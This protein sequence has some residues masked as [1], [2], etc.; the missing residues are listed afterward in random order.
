MVKGRLQNIVHTCVAP[1][2]GK[3]IRQVIL[4]PKVIQS[5]E[6]PGYHASHKM[7]G[8]NIVSLVEPGMW[9]G[10]AVYHGIILSESIADI[11]DGDP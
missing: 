5:N 6:S 2:L 4:R 7:E 1:M 10:R 3:D 11:I 9:K 8:Q